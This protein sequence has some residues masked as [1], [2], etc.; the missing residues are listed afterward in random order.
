MSLDLRWDACFDHAMQNDALDENDA[1]EFADNTAG[2]T[3]RNYKA[4]WREWRGKNNVAKAKHD[5][6][7]CDA[8]LVFDGMEDGYSTWKCSECDWWHIAKDCCA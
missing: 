4:A 7:M 2:D 1:R 5:C 6:G 8:P 3:S